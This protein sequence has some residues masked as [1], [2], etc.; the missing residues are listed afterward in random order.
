M[1]GCACG[2]HGLSEA[3][4]IGH[5]DVS[6][7]AT[8]AIGVVDVERDD[9]IVDER[10]TQVAGLPTVVLA[11]LGAVDAENAYPGRGFGAGGGGVAA[12]EGVAVRHLEDVGVGDYLLA[13]W[14]G[15]GWCGGGGGGGGVDVVGGGV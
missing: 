8:I 14:R 1:P 13:V 11:S 4:S 6:D 7:G 2:Q 9:S 3:L 10:T 12:G 5:D 15:W